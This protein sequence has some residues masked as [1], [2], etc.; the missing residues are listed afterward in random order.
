MYLKQK[1]IAQTYSL[2]RAD[3]TLIASTS[4]K[5]DSQ[6]GE[7]LTTY[8]PLEHA[9]YTTGK[10]A[11]TQTTKWHEIHSKTKRLFQKAQRT[12][13]RKQKSCTACPNSSCINNRL[14]YRVTDLSLTSS[15]VHV[16][17]GFFYLI[18]FSHTH[19][20]YFLLSSDLPF[21]VS[22]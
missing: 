1:Q 5:E 11:S 20:L 22:P 16:F 13:S 19:P 6:A 9:P 7:N 21:C 8:K 3:H 2:S 14:F 17:L 4:F 10:L 15:N 18:V 12:S